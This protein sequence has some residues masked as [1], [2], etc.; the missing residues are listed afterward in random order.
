MVHYE[1]DGNVKCTSLDLIFTTL[2]KCTYDYGK[3]ISASIVSWFALF[4]V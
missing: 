4:N 3:N 1:H 2:Y